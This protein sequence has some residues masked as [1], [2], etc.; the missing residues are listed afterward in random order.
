M[1]MDGPPAWLS[2]D[3]E[4]RRDAEHVGALEEMATAA[5]PD[6]ARAAK[7]LSEAAALREKWGRPLQ[8]FST[9]AEIVT[10]LQAI[11]DEAR[12][13]GDLDTDTVDNLASR[14]NRVAMAL[15]TIASDLERLD[16]DGL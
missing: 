5:H 1:R 11:A 14:T 10:E 16:L 4:E 2:Y 9:V 3:D 15:E 13:M 6:L 12:T 7:L 8:Y